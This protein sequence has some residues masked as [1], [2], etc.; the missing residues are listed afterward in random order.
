MST[1]GIEIVLSRAMSDAAFAD[2]LFADAEKTLAGFELT[3]EERSKLQGMSRAE[4]DAMTTE[5]RKSFI[6][7]NWGEEHQHNENA[8]KIRK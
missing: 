3:S 6:T 4:F 1:K 7:V 5:E 2:A 8:L